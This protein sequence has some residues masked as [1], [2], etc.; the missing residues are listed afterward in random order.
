MAEC[1]ELR[2]ISRLPTNN[3]DEGKANVVFVDGHVSKIKVWRDRRLYGV[4]HAVEGH[5]KKPIMDRFG[6]STGKKGKGII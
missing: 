5:T 3:I 6:K 4:R 1:S 2:Y